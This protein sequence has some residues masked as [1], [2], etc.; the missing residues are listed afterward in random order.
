[1]ETKAG[2]FR[3][4]GVNNIGAIL[5]TQHGRRLN[6]TP[7]GTREVVA[8]IARDTRLFIILNAYSPIT[9][10]TPTK[11]SPSHRVWASNPSSR[12]RRI[13]S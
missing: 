13:G 11:L 2:G 7:S 6:R 5:Q 9:D 4:C 12:L 1:M 10:K 8:E 3:R